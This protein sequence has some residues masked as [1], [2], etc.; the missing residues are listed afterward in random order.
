[1]TLIRDEIGIRSEIKIKV[2]I[3]IEIEIE[4]NRGGSDLEDDIRMNQSDEDN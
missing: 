4:I 2:K 1:L 3:K